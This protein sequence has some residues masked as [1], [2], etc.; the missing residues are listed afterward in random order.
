MV[1]MAAFDFYRQG[2]QAALAKFAFQDQQIPGMIANHG[3]SRARQMLTERMQMG[4]GRQLAPA[5]L[6]QRVSQRLAAAQPQGLLAGAKRLL[7]R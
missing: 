5:V 7:F 3:E 4:S 6:Q 2:A 1:A